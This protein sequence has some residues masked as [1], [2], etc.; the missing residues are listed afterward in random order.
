VLDQLRQIIQ[1][2]LSKEKAFS[3]DHKYWKRIECRPVQLS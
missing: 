2:K 3:F 1:L